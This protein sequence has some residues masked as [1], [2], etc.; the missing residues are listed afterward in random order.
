MYMVYLPTFTM[1]IDQM[2]VDIPYIERLG[3]EWWVTSKPRVVTNGFTAYSM[4]IQDTDVF[5]RDE[6]VKLW[7]FV[8]TSGKAVDA[9]N[10]APVEIG[11]WNPI[12]YGVLYMPGGCFGFLPSTVSWTRS[13]NF[14][15]PKNDGIS[16][17]KRDIIW[18]T[19]M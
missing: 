7:R 2:Q 10:P 9:R 12:I 18:A 13:T 14:S 17:K 8:T 4:P 5:S 16:Q 3:M 6:M 15:R 1:K 11:S 19:N